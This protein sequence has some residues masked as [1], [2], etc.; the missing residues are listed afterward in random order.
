[1]VLSKAYILLIHTM[2]MEYILQLLIVYLLGAVWASCYIKYIVIPK[3]RVTVDMIN[4][5]TSFIIIW[6]SIFIITVGIY[7][8]I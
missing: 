5:T 3:P 2:I 8:M 1:M 4:G 7:S 6:F